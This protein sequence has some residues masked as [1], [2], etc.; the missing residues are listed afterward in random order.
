VRWWCP[1]AW[2]P[3]LLLLH[4]W[5]SEGVGKLL[6]AAQSEQSLDHFLDIDHVHDSVAIQVIGSGRP[7]RN[8]S[9]CRARE[10]ARVGEEVALTALAN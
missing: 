5:D 2:A 3:G 4:G 10:L 6:L 8:A 9:P 7:R 1:F